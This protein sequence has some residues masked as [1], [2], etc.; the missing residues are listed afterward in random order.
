MNVLY[1]VN[2]PLILKWDSKNVKDLSHELIQA[3]RQA[4]A[5]VLH[6]AALL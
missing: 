1:T 5:I 2:L 3:E 6:D 4:S